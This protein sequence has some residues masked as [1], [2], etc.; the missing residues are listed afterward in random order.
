M[1]RRHTSLQYCLYTGRENFHAHECCFLFYWA[2]QWS[3]KSAMGKMLYWRF[4]TVSRLRFCYSPKLS[5]RR[6]TIAENECVICRKRSILLKTRSLRLCLYQSCFK[7]SRQCLRR[8]NSNRA[9]DVF[10]V[11]FIKF[12]RNKLIGRLGF[13]RDVEATVKYTRHSFKSPI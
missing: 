9:R 5:S 7:W 10:H 12:Y 8:C 2:K 11:E 3:T 1:D 6:I 4:L 13:M